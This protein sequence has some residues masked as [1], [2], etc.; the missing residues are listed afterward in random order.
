MVSRKK[1]NLKTHLIINIKRMS[2]D[3]TMMKMFRVKTA[4]VTT[5]RL[6]T[7]TMPRMGKTFKM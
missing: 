2:H 5:D 7:N 1:L 3:T 4:M 6:I